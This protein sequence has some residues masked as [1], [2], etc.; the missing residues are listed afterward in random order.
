MRNGTPEFARQNVRLDTDRVS[1]LADSHLRD[2]ILH[3]RITCEK[4]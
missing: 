1:R 4:G 2:L 3:A